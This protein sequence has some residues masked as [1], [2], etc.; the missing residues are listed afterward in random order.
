MLCRIL[1]LSERLFISNM[2]FLF[3]HLFFP[4]NGKMRFRKVY[5]VTNEEIV[6]KVEFSLGLA[7]KKAL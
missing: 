1:K 2:L 5:W 3:Q 4:L 6:K 7:P